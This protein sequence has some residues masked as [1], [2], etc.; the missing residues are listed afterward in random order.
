ML[1]PWQLPEFTAASMYGRQ[2]DI[3]ARTRAAAA[4][5]QWV[6][7]LLCRA[8][9]S[10]RLVFTTAPPLSQNRFLRIHRTTGLAE[11]VTPPAQTQ[12]R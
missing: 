1:S 4:L 6:A 9:C 7:A 10:K 5:E 3:R 12:T 11:M 8:V 2:L